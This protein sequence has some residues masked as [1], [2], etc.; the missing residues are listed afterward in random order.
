MK[1]EQLTIETLRDRLIQVETDLAEILQRMP[2]HGVKP[3]FMA[4][5]LDLEDERDLFTLGT[6]LTGRLIEN[7]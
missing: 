4:A 1:T 7:A 6:Y 2:S 5:L 3:N